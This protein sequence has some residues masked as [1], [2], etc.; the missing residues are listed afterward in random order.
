[1][2]GCFVLRVAWSIC[3][4]CSMPRGAAPRDWLSTAQGRHFCR[5]ELRRGFG[6]SDEGRLCREACDCQ[7]GIARVA[8]L[9]SLI[10]VKHLLEPTLVAD[11]IS[12]ARQL[13]AILRSIIMKARMSNRRG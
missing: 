13:T 4:G 9:A 7:K 1:M 5:F 8:L 6:R 3:S 10:A 12:E 11:D 2:T